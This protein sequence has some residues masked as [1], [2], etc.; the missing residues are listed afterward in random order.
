VAHTATSSVASNER[1]EC[2]RST[3]NNVTLQVART[4]AEVQDLLPIWSDWCDHPSLDAEVLLAQLR[5]EGG[6]LQPYVITLYRDGRPDCL[7]AGTLAVDHMHLSFGGVRLLLPKARLIRVETN[8]FLGNRTEENSRLVVGELLK[9]LERKDADGVE[10]SSLR[11]DSPLYGCATTLPGL[12]SRDYFPPQMSHYSLLP[13][14]TFQKFLQGLSKKKRRNYASYSKKLRRAFPGQ[15]RVR[16]F[17]R[18]ADVETL[19]RDC[20][21]IA[22]KTYQRRLNTGFVNDLSTQSMMRAYHAKGMLWGY[23]LDIA[24]QPSAF[25]IGVSHYGTAYPLFM[26]YDPKYRNF[27][28]GFFLLMRYLRKVC[29][30]STIRRVDFG[31]GNHRYKREICNEEWREA[32]VSIFAPYPKWVAVNLLRTALALA[33]HAAIRVLGSP[34]LRDTSVRAWRRIVMAKRNW[35]RQAVL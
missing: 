5:D 9:A 11:T 17:Q 10:F 29:S 19:L 13:P 14:S 6:N 18:I 7:L 16:S 15:I 22:R 26:A 28:P 31:H 21:Q 30:T 20:E 34:M 32:A 27:S 4:A 35:M 3:T 12:L 25:I 8:A 33:R 23:V 1:E 24:G 2:S